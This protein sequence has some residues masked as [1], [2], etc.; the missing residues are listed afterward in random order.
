[1]HGQNINIYL[2][3]R[4]R[5]SIDNLQKTIK[6]LEE[7]KVIISKTFEESEHQEKN[8]NI[9]GFETLRSCPNCGNNNPSQ[10]REMTDKTIII[11]DYPKLYGERY[12]C[13][14]CGTEWN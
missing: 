3:K 1:M 6:N 9:Y 8:I 10:I 4:K 7:E 12:H 11:S 13:G 14:Q 2:I 5:I